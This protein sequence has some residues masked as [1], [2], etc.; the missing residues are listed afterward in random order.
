MSFWEPLAGSASSETDLD[1]L[2]EQVQEL[3]RL[4][5]NRPAS[6]GEFVKY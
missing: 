5:E 1:R 3:R 2:L 6:V 4:I